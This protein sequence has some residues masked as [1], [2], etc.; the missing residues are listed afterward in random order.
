MIIVPNVSVRSA[1]AVWRAHP[2]LYK[3]FSSE[4]KHSGMAARLCNRYF[5]ENL[6]PMI[7]ILQ[8]ISL[9]SDAL[10]ARNLTLTKAEQ[11][12]KRTIKVFEMLK[13]SKG[14]YEKKID[15]MAASESFKDIHFVE[16]NKVVSLPC[17]KVLEAVGETGVSCYRGTLL[18][19]HSLLL[20]IKIN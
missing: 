17:Q 20:E 10:Q 2:A 16:N 3:Y 18:Q 1:L 8:E 11:L 7:D 13:E 4:A 12:V 15:D 9:L 19:P 6:A 14:T 5:L